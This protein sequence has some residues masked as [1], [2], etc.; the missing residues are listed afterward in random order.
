MKQIGVRD[1]AKMVGGFGA[2]GR[3]LCCHTFLENFEPV[4]IRM[5]KLQNL[6][7]DPTKISGLCG[8]LMCCL[9]YEFSFYDEKRKKLPKHGET[10]LLNNEKGKVSALDYIKNIVYVELPEGR[11]VKALGDEVK[12]LKEK[13]R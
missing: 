4:S 10:V 9:E 5:A 11:I 2:C 1:E 8:R 6:S 7:L 13:K 12:R 3:G